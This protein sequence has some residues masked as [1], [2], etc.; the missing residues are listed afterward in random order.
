MPGQARARGG[1]TRGV[2]MRAGSRRRR[3]F[4]AW[5]SPRFWITTIATLRTGKPSA[6]QQSAV[7]R[8]WK[9]RLIVDE[10]STG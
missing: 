7:R 2:P 9:D 10:F 1:D 3:Q 8:E 4:E 6:G 5:S